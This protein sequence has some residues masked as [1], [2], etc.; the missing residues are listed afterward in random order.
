MNLEYCF[1]LKI[2]LFYHLKAAASLDYHRQ[3]LKRTDAFIL[4]FK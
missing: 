3:N 1:Y 2:Q 4:D